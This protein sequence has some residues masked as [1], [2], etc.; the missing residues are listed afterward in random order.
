MRYCTARASLI[1]AQSILGARHNPRY[2][3][4]ITRPHPFPIR[5]SK[6]SID[7]LPG[8][9]FTISHSGNIHG[10]FKLTL[11]APTIPTYSFTFHISHFPETF[12]QDSSTN[13]GSPD[14]RIYKRRHTHTDKKYDTS[15]VKRH[16]RNNV[17]FRIFECAA[18]YLIE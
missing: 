6:D 7:D 13:I 18:H 3:S 16:T 4:H 9:P 14:E 2:A 8:H 15:C 5:Y 17:Y 11:G 1:K 12:N 10:P